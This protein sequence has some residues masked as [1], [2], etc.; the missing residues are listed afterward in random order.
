VRAAEH[1]QGKTA[2]HQAVWRNQAEVIKLLLGAYAPISH[3]P[4]TILI[5]VFN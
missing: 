3:S 5:H 4:S 1:T 2:L